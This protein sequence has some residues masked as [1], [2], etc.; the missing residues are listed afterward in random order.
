MTTPYEQA[1]AAADPH[2]V[3]AAASS[4]AAS[5]VLAELGVAAELEALHDA[6]PVTVA[7]GDQACGAEAAV[8]AAARAAEAAQSELVA[9]QAQAAGDPG[10]EQAAEAVSAAQAAV[11]SA[12][13]ALRQAIEDAVGAAEV[14]RRGLIRRHGGVQENADAAGVL[15]ERRFH[16]ASPA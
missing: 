14:M 5:Q 3:R 8:V 9:A 7:E 11:A 1:L 15:A 13:A 6:G 16:G 10:N 12:E 4:V 2:R